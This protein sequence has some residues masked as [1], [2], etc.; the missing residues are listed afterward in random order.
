MTASIGPACARG[1][2]CW[3]PASLT[4]LYGCSSQQQ[5]K[6]LTGWCVTAESALCVVRGL[7]SVAPPA[8]TDSR[9]SV[10]CWQVRVSKDLNA[11]NGASVSD[12]WAGLLDEGVRAV[13]DP[14]VAAGLVAAKKVDA[15]RNS[16]KAD[17]F[18][19]LSCRQGVAYLR[20]AGLSKLTDAKEHEGLRKDLAIQLSGV[21]GRTASATVRTHRDLLASLV[22]CTHRVQA[23]H[24]FPAIHLHRGCGVRPDWAGMPPLSTRARCHTGTSRSW[25]GRRSCCPSCGLRS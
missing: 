13:C 18:P 19:G 7:P 2:R 14:V 9:R 15:V 10:P 8:L 23:T 1:T 22:L 17:T 16:G 12:S 11:H 3:R 20:R 5:R 21:R 24:C 4:R 6:T 25:S